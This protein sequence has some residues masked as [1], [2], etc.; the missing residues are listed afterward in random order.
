MPQFSKCLL[1]SPLLCQTPLCEFWIQWRIT[2]MELPASK[3]SDC[4]KEGHPLGCEGR[5]GF[6]EDDSG[7][8]EVG[9]IMETGLNALSIN[10]VQSVSHVWLSATPWTAACQHHQ[11]PESTRAHVHRVGNAI[12]PAHPLSSPSPPTF[13]LSQHQGLFQWISSSHQVAKV[14]EFQLRISPS[15]L[16]FPLCEI[17]NHW[18]ILNRE[19]TWSNLNVL[20]IHVNCV[21]EKLKDGCKDTYQESVTVPLKREFE[22]LNQSI[23]GKVARAV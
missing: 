12:Q 21:D 19:A 8:D 16:A 2:C 7:G 14:L 15:N 1:D 11:L 13:D 3:N 10:S 9:E 5:E 18:R 17:R 20:K 6:E 4:S 22:S 23:T